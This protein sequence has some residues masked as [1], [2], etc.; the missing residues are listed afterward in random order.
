MKKK[1]L[2]I[3]IFYI[4]KQYNKFMRLY[5]KFN[6]KKGIDGKRSEYLGELRV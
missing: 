1:C 6:F 3:C 2:R 5:M 4:V